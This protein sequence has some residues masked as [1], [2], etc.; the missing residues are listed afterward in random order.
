MT[1]SKVILGPLTD[2]IKKGIDY[3]DTK[4]AFVKQEDNKYFATAL[5]DL[6]MSSSK[7]K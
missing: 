6:V 5:T 3:V 1:E 4:F 7:G 2:E